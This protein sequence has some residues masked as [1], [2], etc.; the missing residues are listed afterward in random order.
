MSHIKRDV[1]DSAIVLRR[2]AGQQGRLAE[3]SVKSAANDNDNQGPWPLVRF[4]ESPYPTFSFEDFTKPHRTSWKGK[5][6]RLAYVAAMPFAVLGW[7]YLL[8]L[9]IISGTEWILS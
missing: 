3:R 7:L 6:I 9:A 8:W 2:S 5:L 4:L 1:P